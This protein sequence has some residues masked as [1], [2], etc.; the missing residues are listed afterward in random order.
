[1]TD[2]SDKPDV[3]E[4]ILNF[5]DQIAIIRSDSPKFIQLFQQMYS[6][7]QLKKMESSDFPPI[8]LH[9]QSGLYDGTAPQLILDDAV[10]S[11]A[12]IRFNDGYIYETILNTII[13]RVRSHFLIHAGVISR[14]NQGIV[15]VADSAHGKTT[16]VLELLRRGF[17]FLS[18]E[19]AALGRKDHRVHPFPRSLRIRPGTLELTGFQHAAQNATTWLDKLLIDIDTLKNNCVG[20]AV[21]IQHIVIFKDP[22]FSEI[23]RNID[24]PR[25]IMVVV[26]RVDDKFIDCIR[27]YKQ[28]Q[29][30][31]VDRSRTYPLLH[32]VASHTTTLLSR[33]E[34]LC[35]R[36]KILLLNYLRKETSRPKFDTHPQLVPISKTDAVREILRRFLGGHKSALL[37][38]EFDGNPLKLYM[39]L[40][41]IVNQ[42][43]CHRLYVGTLSGMADLVSG[44]LLPTEAE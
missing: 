44:L 29:D 24:T 15:L 25:K 22:A 31:R 21:P 8:N 23:E 36:Y 6:R 39:E 20:S 28:V 33:I 2:I 16:L 4:I 9:I 40:S 26:D 34:A 11:L 32:I 1:V 10:T 42:A 12:G 30:L 18:D 38:S 14:N 41:E 19:M 43:S 5:Y 27:G 35:V 7:F 37:Q 3:S 13:S 17:N